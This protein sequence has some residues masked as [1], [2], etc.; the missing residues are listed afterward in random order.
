MKDEQA[1]NEYCAGIMDIKLKVYPEEGCFIYRCPLGDWEDYNPYN[2]LNQL[3][4]VV[5]KL[6]MDIPI[7]NVLRHRGNRILATMYHEMS[8][9]AAVKQAFQSFIISCM[10]EK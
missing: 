9:G 5:E 2:D 6:I 4:P 7:V 3:A 10:E 8:S 1:F